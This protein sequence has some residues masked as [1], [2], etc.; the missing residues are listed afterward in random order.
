MKRKKAIIWTVVL[1]LV[2]AGIAAYVFA[3]KSKKATP[4]VTPQASGTPT[5]SPGT[6]GNPGDEDKSQMGSSSPTPTPTVQGSGA[7]GSNSSTTPAINISGF[8]ATSPASGKVHVSSIVTGADEGGVCTVTLKSTSGAS[9]APQTF[10]VTNAG[11]YFSCSSTFSG[12]PAGTWTVSLSVSEAGKT[13]N[14]PSANVT[15]N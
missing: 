7:Q 14:A 5:P 2:A 9:Q 4:T 1:V 3:G 11:T 13:S 8:G 10:T 12:I 15:V 6:V